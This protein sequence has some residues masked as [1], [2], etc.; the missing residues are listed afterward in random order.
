MADLIL[1]HFPA[2]PFSE[3]TRLILGFKGLA[4]KSV[5]VPMVMP[6]PDVVAL[7]GGYRKTPF[8]QI[9]ADIYCDTALIAEVLERIELEPSLFPGQ[10][11]GL[12]RTLAQWADSTLFWAA[13]RFNR[14]IKG[15][16]Q[17]IGGVAP[18]IVK[19]LLEDRKAMGF[20]MEW[21]RPSDAAT[22]LQAYLLRLTEILGEKQ[23]LLGAEP[24]IADFAAVHSLWYLCARP[25]AA[26][27]LAQV[28]RQLQGWISRMM[29]I[30][31]GKREEI[32]SAKS[33]EIASR[34]QPLPLDQGL[35]KVDGF[36]DS[37]GVALGSRVA[38]SAANFGL[39]PTEGDLI[40]ATAMHYTLRRTDERAG[41][42]H[43]HFPRIGYVLKN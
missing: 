35:L 29:A 31:H 38:I 18:E 41:T 32:D 1:H 13:I 30:G 26:M 17:T 14:G 15:S 12:S 4:W 19:V 9:G 42:I 21:V 33:I 43:V 5:T 20:D 24:C 36:A 3:K 39:E 28:D 34:S 27:S 23:Y 11:A 8:L 7:T 22:P 37:H 2:S 40:A 10:G 25:G 16:G 6:K